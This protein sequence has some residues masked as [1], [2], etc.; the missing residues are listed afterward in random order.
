MSGRF[1]FPFITDEPD[2]VAGFVAVAPVTILSDQDQLARISCP[3]LAIWG[4]HDRTIPLEQADLFVR[5]VKHGRKVSIPGGSH[6][7]YTS[8]PPTFHAERLDF[9][10]DLE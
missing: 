3:V 5:P 1:A 8:D 9:L 2:K 6:A 7:P 10:G 4:D